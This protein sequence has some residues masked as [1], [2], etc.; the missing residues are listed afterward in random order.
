MGLLAV[1]NFILILGFTF[2]QATT[3]G[4]FIAE[5]GA[6]RLPYAYLSIA[7]LA[8]VVAF[9]YL[10]LSGRIDF[11]RLITLNLGFLS[12]MC[13]LFWAGLGTAV[14]RWFIFLLP[15]WF[16]TQINL[17][18]LV[19]WPLAGRIFDLR[20]AKRLF[21]LVG[22][23]IWLA[24]ILGG[25]IIAPFA[26]LIG[27]RN[28]LL[29]TAVA[30]ALSIWILRLII[31]TSLSQPVA[32][33]NVRSQPMPLTR[34]KQTQP[35]AAF[36]IKDRYV[37]LIFAYIMIW[38]ISFYFIDNMFYDRAGTQFT[39]VVQLTGFIGQ[40]LSAIG[41]VALITTT[42]I[43]GRVI[44]RFGLKAGLLAMPVLVTLI[45]AAMAIIGSAS[46]GNPLLF[47]L[48]SAAKLINVALGFSISQSAG[49]LL[50]QPLPG[51]QR[52][53]TQTIAEG[54]V[55]PLAIGLAGLM[56]LLLNTVLHLG[57]VVLSYVYL[58]IAAG[59]I[60]VI[61][62]MA[63]QYP[64][65]LSQALERRQLGA[66]TLTLIDATGVQ[67]LQ[68]SLH[69]PHAGVVLYAMQHLEEWNLD[70]WKATLHE[71]LPTL[72]AHPEPEVRRKVLENLELIG[73]NVAREI[74]IQALTKE[75]DPNVT[76]IGLRALAANG[77]AEALSQV[78]RFL[79]DQS[80]IVQRGALVAMMRHGG[81]D[82]IMAAGQVFSQW[83][84]SPDARQRVQAADVLGE[85][86]S[87]RFYQ[88]VVELL[89]DPQPSVRRAATRAAGRIQNAHLWPAVF[90]ACASPETH[91]LAEKALVAGGPSVLP[92]VSAEIQRLT[93][94]Q[95]ARLPG[96]DGQ[97]LKS[98]VEVCG[99]IGGVQAI[100][101]LLGQV[102]TPDL[103][104]RQ[105]ILQALN[106]CGYRATPT[107]A[108]LN[109]LLREEVHLGAWITAFQHRLESSD[110][111]E[112]LDTLLRRL[113]QD[114]RDRVLTMLS[115]QYDAQALLRAR[116]ALREGIASQ[117]VYALEIIENQIPA[118]IKSWAMPLAEQST[119]SERLLRFQGAGIQATLPG[120]DAAL[121]AL[122]DGNIKLPAGVAQP[123]PLLFSAWVQASVLYLI[124]SQEL[125]TCSPEVQAACASPEHLVSESARWALIRLDG[126]SAK[127]VNML[128]PI[129]KVLILKTADVFT[130]V[131]DDV[132]A[133]VANYLE[134]IDVA[135][136]ENIF[137]KGD[138]GSSMYILV[139]GKVGVHDN[140]ISLN[141]LGEGD[142][143]GEM[144]LLDPEPRSA[145]VTALEPT[146]LLRLDQEPFMELIA[147]DPEVATGIIR[148][149]T[150]YLR[151]RVQDLNRL[152]A[153][154]R[155]CEG[156]QS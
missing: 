105:H 116:A 150:R 58:G 39:E 156:I 7:L 140:G 109:R 75:T 148:N 154:L 130:H 97:R 79:H 32:H 60:L 20:Q 149:L 135:A 86:G 36:N 2:L 31:N 152:D 15:F 62:W 24:N 29:I 77:D 128:S 151:A 6:Q 123:W 119:P 91:C 143:F 101:N 155:E 19:V 78:T 12:L 41:I 13:L 76:A 67:A 54:I 112:L 127:G 40:L 65:V 83:I 23:G 100:E 28:L 9:I 85:V 45:I 132:L 142:V 50:Y 22:S 107:D 42:M 69:S 93:G 114:V 129:E 141:T 38:W 103:V 64:R 57:V 111:L 82:S 56:L 25:F 68:R 18:N 1:L 70:A 124:G 11:P 87:A 122:L 104:L 8:S 26:S 35:K 74:V 146:Q 10:K 63:A 37:L 145:S 61:F 73:T 4:M 121:L 90:E 21:G 92:L 46:P 136:N 48:A 131:P 96:P 47:W 49:N 126:Q 89:R 43:T 117:Q 66:S 139:S 99:Q 59:W 108:R 81:I 120:D 44:T 30:T 55:Q 27:T 17:I 115:F 95:P 118:K 88:P 98:L 71:N 3:F 51:A 106:R 5:F 34:T 52:S 133:D 138:L 14:A 125:R 137:H 16:Q 94:G 102:E 84:Q 153:R 144:A 134:E 80:P 147:Q 33:T 53:Q 110:H 113:L 72:L